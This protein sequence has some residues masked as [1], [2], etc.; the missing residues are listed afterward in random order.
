MG[1]FF[2]KTKE[3]G[4]KNMYK[5]YQLFVC[6]NDAPSKCTKCDRCVSSVGEILF[7]HFARPA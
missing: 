3:D 5:V 1:T 7:K 6:P 4:T 2:Y